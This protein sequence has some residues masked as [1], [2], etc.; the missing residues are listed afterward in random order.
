[1]VVMGFSPPEEFTVINS[2]P[3]GALIV[4]DINATKPVVV[5]NDG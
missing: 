2:S 1:M 5:R 4:D 3:F